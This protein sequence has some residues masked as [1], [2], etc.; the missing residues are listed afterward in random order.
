MRLS[1]F[2]R[3]EYLHNQRYALIQ[4]AHL[5]LQL[6]IQMIHN[7]AIDY[8]IMELSDE[9]SGEDYSTVPPYKEE[10]LLSQLG[11][12][13]LLAT[14]KDFQRLMN[15]SIVTPDNITRL[16]QYNASKT[17]S[18][19]LTQLEVERINK[20]LEWV[21]K[22]L[23]TADYDIGLY[24]NL[25]EKVPTQ[26]SRQDVLEKALRDGQNYKG[27]EYTYKELNRLSRDLEK[28]KTSH[29]DYEV[30]RL[31]NRQADREG[32]PAPNT[33]KTWIWSQLEHTRHNGMDGETVRFGEKF[34]VV[35]EVTGDVD[36]LRFPHDVENDYNNCSNICNCACSYEIN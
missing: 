6:R 14:S 18:E 8:R 15:R 35:N 16:E 33:T 9:L 12:E 4:K 27:R 11:R 19:R 24:K 7:R 32:L 30:A 2:N 31:E 28:Y 22:T 17:I 29:M 23:E 36:Y 34:E 1:H 13:N 26:V 20:N 10:V 25:I 3:K 21:E 5:P